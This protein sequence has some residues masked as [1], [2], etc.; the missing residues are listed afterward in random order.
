MLPP[1]SEKMKLMLERTLLRSEAD[2]INASNA[3]EEARRS[4]P[5][6]AEGWALAG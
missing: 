6:E 4:R 5:E 3:A 1:L 2:A